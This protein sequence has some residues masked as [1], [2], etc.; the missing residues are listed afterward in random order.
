MATQKLIAEPEGVGDVDRSVRH[1]IRVLTPKDCVEGGGSDSVRYFLN[2][3]GR[4]MDKAERDRRDS[5]QGGGSVWIFL[6]GGWSVVDLERSMS[7]RTNIYGAEPYLQGEARTYWTAA[8]RDLIGLFPMRYWRANIGGQIADDLQEAPQPSYDRWVE[9]DRSGRVI[10]FMR[11]KK[12]RSSVSP[13]CDFWTS[14][15]H[16][17][18]SLFFPTTERAAWRKHKENGLRAIACSIDGDSY[19]GVSPEQLKRWRRGD[20]SE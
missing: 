5:K 4:C 15:G 20:F 7:I 13:H 3:D 10:G 12:P 19:P 18:V 8:D 9:R 1:K 17:D 2:F 11:C 6:D 16:S 14:F